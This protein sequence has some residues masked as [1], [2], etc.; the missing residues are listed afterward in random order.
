MKR[1]KTGYA[2]LFGAMLMVVAGHAAAASDTVLLLYGTNVLRF[3]VESGVWTAQAEFANKANNYGGKS[4][5]FKGLAS[6]GR[7][8]FVGESAATA[9]RI[10]EFDMEGN[11]AGFLVTIGKPVEHLTVSQDGR[12]LYANVS[13]NFSAP[14]ADASVYRYDPV[15]RA[16][17]LFIPNE[18][19]NELGE[20]LWKFQVHR[21]VATDAEGNVWVSERSTGKVFKFSG[22]D[23]SYLGAV[24]GL[25]G[26]QGLYYVSGENKLYCTSNSNNSYVIDVATGTAVTRTISGA[27]NRL[28]LTRVGGVFYSARYTEG[29]ISRYDF[30]A[31]TR[32]T[33]VTT[34]AN[35]SELIALPHEPLR[36]TAGHLLVSETVSNRVARVTV[37]A[38]Y[39]V[40]S[41]GVFAGV[42]GAV[43][44]GAPLRQPRGLAAHS[45]TVY[46]AEGVAGGRILKFSKWGTFKGV[47]ADFSQTAYPGCVPAALALTT[48]GGTLY[49]TDAHTLFL[50]GGNSDWGNVPTNGYYSVNG[51]GETVYK[52][53]LRSRNVSVFANSSALASGNMLLEPQGLAVDGAGNVYCTAWFNKTNALYQA[54]GSI[55]QFT[56]AGGLAASFDIGNPSVCY[57]DPAG[58]Y[59]PEAANSQISGA[60]I[61][62]TGNGMQDFW[63]TA[64][65]SGMTVRPKMLDLGNWRNYL[66]I[67]VVGGRMWFTDPEYGTLWRRM[68]ETAREASVTGLFMPTYLTYVTETGGEPPPQGTMVSVR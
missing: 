61:L 15:T 67:E 48:D 14:T 16:G 40:E 24:T 23:G 29:D 56:P 46:V 21:G 7:R 10:L 36:A 2:G 35:A 8:V 49:V 55:Y 63:W 59:V 51:F 1:T 44:G 12:W 26:V 54:T 6:D 53:E 27:S 11:F 47:V 60:G 45:N 64:A 65:G 34:G 31:L 32:V 13:P 4:Y 19:T 3:A 33:E 28:G 39:A 52:V 20:V 42:A 22:V 43:Y 68:G 25:S 58:T 30:G 50:A 37:Y 66:D 5:N 38:D 41:K 18:G 17:G 57:Y 62:F 9:S